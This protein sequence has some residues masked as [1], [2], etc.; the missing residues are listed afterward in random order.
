[1]KKQRITSTSLDDNS[2]GQ[3]DW[4]S[5]NNLTDTEVHQA[6]L[7][8]PDAAPTTP[9]DWADAALLDLED[10]ERV[11]SGQIQMKDLME[12]RKKRRK[13]R[14]V[15][16]TSGLEKSSRNERTNGRRHWAWIS[17]VGWYGHDQRIREPLNSSAGT[18]RSAAPQHQPLSATRCTSVF[19]SVYRTNRRNGSR[20]TSHSRRVSSV[21]D[22]NPVLMI[23]S[24]SVAACPV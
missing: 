24:A 1:M 20:F 15:R 7:K 9:E 3:T 16:S 19:S 23:D 13:R 21:P 4:V 18:N 8:D 6:A 14:R 10:H 11:Q 5:V 2:K 17:P 22:S 12:Q